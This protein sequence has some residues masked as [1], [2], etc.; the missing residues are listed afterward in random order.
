MTDLTAVQASSGF[1]YDLRNSGL[2]PDTEARALLGLTTDFDVLFCERVREGYEFVFAERVRVRI[3]LMRRGQTQGSLDGEGD[4][5]EGNGYGDSYECTCAVFRGKDVACQHIFWLLDQVQGQLLSASPSPSRVPSKILLS[6]DGHAQG[7]PRI[8]QLL[9]SHI[10][11]ESL[12]DQLDWP[13]VRSAVEEG[14]F[15]RTQRVRDIL[16]AFSTEILPEEFRCDLAE[17]DF[18]PEDSTG[19]SHISTK[20]R[21]TPEQCVVQGDM[22]TTVFRLA[23]N[24]DNVFTSLCKAMPPG[25]CAAIYFD[26]AL[27][28]SR[29]ILF[30][31][32]KY[33]QT[34]GGPT[35]IKN[36]DETGYKGASSV[37]AFIQAL[38]TNTINIHKNIHARAP[39]GLQ[40]AAE[41]LTTI[42][43]DISRRNNDVLAENKYGRV[44]FSPAN[45]PEDE[46]SRNLYQQ[47]IG[48]ADDEDE[49]GVYFVLD[50]LADLPGEDL[51]QFRERLGTVL[52][53]V[54]VNR[55]PRGFIMKL[56]GIVRVAEAGTG[57]A[58]AR[59]RAGEMGGERGRKRMR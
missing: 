56:A 39:H 41:A 27:E 28:R 58:I 21:R 57:T 24:D 42:L 40:G 35:E 1:V 33:C 47:L 37:A 20:E 9:S 6:S 38:K 53:R 11:L 18:D 51:H 16:S 23:V 25:A 29:K 32:D 14:G 50:A 55:A 19:Y 7:F 46:D 2:G 49:E 8:E 52:R 3:P 12:A 10:T 48:N 4:G 43:E 59:K 30:E 54:E 26:K 34:L 5:V 31:F 17:L 44:S 13:Y 15:S 45:T 22:E 36:Q